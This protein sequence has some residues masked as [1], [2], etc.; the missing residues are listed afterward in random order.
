MND[1]Q[2]AGQVLMPEER[3]WSWDCKCLDSMDC[4]GC[5]EFVEAADATIEAQGEATIDCATFYPCCLAQQT[6]CLT[7]SILF[8]T[9]NRLD[10][11]LLS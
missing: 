3:A 11:V 10:L 6:S 5:P 2:Q 1:T 9:D 4:G 7:A 8:Q